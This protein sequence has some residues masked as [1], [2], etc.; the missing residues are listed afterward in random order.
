MTRW[1]L[2]L[3]LVLT[4]P[5]CPS[6]DGA[7]ALL[8]FSFVYRVD[9]GRD[10]FQVQN[11]GY[12][13]RVGA[14]GR[15]ERLDDRGQL[16]PTDESRLDEQSA[17]RI[18]SLFEQVDFSTL[19]SRL[20]RGAGVAG[21]RTVTISIS[22]LSKGDED[23]SGGAATQHTVIASTDQSELFDGP[24]FLRFEQNLSSILEA[25][26]PAP[27]AEQ[28]EGVETIRIPQPNQAARDQSRSQ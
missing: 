4:P 8:P 2:G 17:E 22:G 19:P 10:C 28:L 7:D 18:V 16:V 1:V 9:L 27:D 12:E 26:V 20:P 3:A 21:G 6:S 15:V 13:F 24:A 25:L 5:G 23:A 14:D 11:C